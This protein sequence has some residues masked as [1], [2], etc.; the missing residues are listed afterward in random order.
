M[1]GMDLYENYWWL[2]AGLAGVL[3]RLATEAESHS[4]AESSVKPLNNPRTTRNP[5]VSFK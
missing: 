1:F 2:A 3:V 4:K 5:I